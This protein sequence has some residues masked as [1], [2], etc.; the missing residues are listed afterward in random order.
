[1]E[2]INKGIPLFLMG[3]NI[4]H[5]GYTLLIYG[6]HGKICQSVT[7]LVYLKYAILVAIYYSVLPPIKA[8]YSFA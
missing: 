4:Q 5:L 7:V 2:P 8:R 6:A 1:M 3:T